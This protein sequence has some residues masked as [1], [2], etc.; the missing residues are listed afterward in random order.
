MKRIFIGF[1]ICLLLL[2][3]VRKEENLEIK[4]KAYII[5]YED[6]KLQKYID[7]LKENSS[8]TI[9][10]PRKGFY[11]EHQ[12]LIDK[13][14]NLYFYQ[15]EY[16]REFCSYGSENDTLPHL[17]FLKPKDIVRVPQKSLTDFLSENI[18]IKEKNRQI[19]IVASQND[20]IQNT[21]FFEFLNK[22]NIGNYI[23][24]RTTQ[25]EDTVLQYKNN[26][27]KYFYYYPDSIKWDKTKIKVPSNRN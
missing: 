13:K 7:S 27:R 1:I 10:F 11:G 12:L 14:G 26:D 6:E 3:C 18:L 2:N 23:I 22:K 16:Y 4:N 19:L 5:S 20:T 9:A 17:L 21:S 8:K 24:R 25:E 15:K